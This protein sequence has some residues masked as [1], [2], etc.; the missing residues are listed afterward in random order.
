VDPGGVGAEHAIAAGFCE[1]SAFS[2]RSSRAGT[3][4][5]ATADVFHTQLRTHSKKVQ[6][7]VHIYLGLSQQT[8]ECADLDWLV[9]RNHATPAAAP[10][11]HT[12]THPQP[13]HL[14]RWALIEEKM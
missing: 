3:R 10:H 6:K 1:G 9:E 8:S 11:H 12:V 7:F 2:K 13:D 5:S 4:A 14:R